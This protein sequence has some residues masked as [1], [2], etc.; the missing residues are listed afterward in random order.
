MLWLAVAHDSRTNS[1][2]LLMLL[3]LTSNEKRIGSADTT[4]G[5]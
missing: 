2:R 5:L 1:G 4:R 3:M